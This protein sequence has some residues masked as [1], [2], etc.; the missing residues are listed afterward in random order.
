MELISTSPTVGYKVILNDS[1]TSLV[2]NPSDL[3][4]PS[5]MKSILEPYIKDAL[6]TTK[7]MGWR[8]MIMKCPRG[9]IGSI[10]KDKE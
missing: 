9:S 2:N 4:N 5:E 1:T 6:H 8:H 10:I 7:W 3:P